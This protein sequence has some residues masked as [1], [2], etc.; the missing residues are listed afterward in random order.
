MKHA[1]NDYDRIQDPEG[2]IPEGEPVFLI[3]GQDSVGPNAVRYWARLAKAAGAASNIVE[4]ANKQADA[5][6]VWQ[7]EHGYKIPDMP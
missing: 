6:G 1:R 3:R 4:T 7:H 2:K 5:M